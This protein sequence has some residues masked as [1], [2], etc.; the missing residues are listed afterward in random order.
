MKQFNEKTEKKIYQITYSI[1]TIFF[2]NILIKS[3]TFFKNILI[4]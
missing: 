4:V 1:I 2:F 3:R